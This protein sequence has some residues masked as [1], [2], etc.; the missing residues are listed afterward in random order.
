[1]RGT[2]GLCAA[3]LLLAASCSSRRHVTGDCAVIDPRACDS[4]STSTTTRTPSASSPVTA[5]SSTPIGDDAGEGSGDMESAVTVTPVVAGGQLTFPVSGGTLPPIVLQ[6]ITSAS[7][8]F[9]PS[10]DPAK[11]G[12]NLPTPVGDGTLVNNFSASATTTVDGRIQLSSNAV[13]TFFDQRPI[14]DILAAVQQILG[15]TADNSVIVDNNVTPLTSAGEL[16]SVSQQITPL[17][18]NG[19]TWDL[20]GHEF[21]GI[22]AHLH[23]LRVV[24]TDTA[25]TGK[26]PS[27]PPAA[28]ATASDTDVAAAAASIVGIVTGWK[29]TAGVP[30]EDGS[31]FQLVVTVTHTIGDAQQAAALLATAIGGT[32]FT[33][34][35][36]TVIVTAGASTWAVTATSATL[37]AAGTWGQQ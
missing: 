26:L 16:R 19:P 1:M 20:S 7:M 36:N 3:A 6:R 13:F 33:R 8:R 29:I 23:N 9:A 31:T 18:G 35:A 34:D 27:I 15:V 24:R 28:A 32:A 5:G 30:A 4:S 21:G 12:I 11:Y 22:L 14:H 17:E 37:T 25:T 10:T 2:I